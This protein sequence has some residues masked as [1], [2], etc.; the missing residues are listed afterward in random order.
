MSDASASFSAG[1]YTIDPIYVK[2]EEGGT[3]TIG[4]KLET[5]T[6][7]WCIWDNFVLTYYG[8]EASIDQVKNAAVFAQLEELKA[9][10]SQMLVSEEIEV[11]SVVT[12]LQN[13]LNNAS[14]EIT[15]VEQA[16][17]VIAGLQD[18]IAKGETYIKAKNV[19]AQMKKLTES[20]NVYTEEAYNEYYGQWYQKY[21]AAELT[22]AEANALQDPYVITGWRASNNVDD[23]LMSVWDAEPMDWATYHINTWSNE[24]VSDGSNFVVPFFEYW[25]GDGESLVEKTLTATMNGITAGWYDV[26]AL[27]RVRVKNGNTD[28]AYGIKMQAN[29][30]D[31]TN[32]CTGEQVPNTQFY[33]DQ[34]T[35]KGEVGEDGVL[36]IKFIVAGNNNISWLS[37]QN[38]KFAEGVATNYDYT[39]V[40]G[41]GTEDGDKDDPVFTKT[42]D[43][44]LAANN[45]SDED[46]DGV[47]TLSFNDVALNPGTKILYKVVRSH[48]WDI[49]WGFNATVENPSGNAD[50]VVNLP[51]GKILPEGMTD[52]YFDITFKFNPTTVFENGYNVDCEVVYDEAKTDNVATGIRSIA[53]AEAQNGNVYNLNGQKVQSLKKGLYIVNGKKQ[54]VR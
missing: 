34:F 15:S 39:L 46:E 49:T 35:A 6:A 43:P 13:V 26:T 1:K 22:A 25:T 20:T 52:G 40:G 19:L 27:V 50:Y 33:L 2:V 44:T 10:L 53:A 4:A 54:V 29:D 14:G 51:E 16:E 11:E 30:G 17:I 42:W 7:L 24:G 23:L 47:Y 28:A 8:A 18:A 5:N 31:M 38:V 41:C 3:L 45:L 9:Q 37:F 48:S 12:E 32:V 36:K 21:E